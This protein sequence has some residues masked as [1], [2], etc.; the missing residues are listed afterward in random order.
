MTF[1]QQLR[2]AIH[3]NPE[4]D[5]MD[6]K[7]RF[8][9]GGEIAGYAD[10][11]LALLAAAGIPERAAVGV[12][13]R[14]KPLQ[15]AAMLG[16][17][18]GDRWLTTVYAMQT[19]GSIAQELRDTRFAAVIADRID[20]T[21]EVVA[22]AR[23]CG[24]VGLV[25]DLDAAAPIAV[26]PE[27]ATGGPGPFRIMDG[28]PGLEILSSGTTGKPK[29]IVFPTRI[30][31]RMVDS[32]KV[33]N[34]GKA[35]PSI[36]AWP[37]SGIGGMCDLVASPLMGRHVALLERFNVG[38][39]VDAVERL[40]PETV[41]G[42]PTIARMVLD[43][44]VPRERLA[45]VKYFVGGSAPM[46]PELQDEF[47]E[48][49]GIKVIW[50]YGATEFCGTII[51]WTPD[52]HAQFRKAKAGSMG[53][54]LPGITLRVLDVDSGEILPAGQQGFLSALVPQVKDEWIDTTDLVVIDDDG[55]VFH[56]GRGDGAILRG[57]HKVIP[58]KVINC[59]RDHPSVLDA[60]VVGLPD[61]RLGGVPAAVVE[62]KADMPQVDEAEL[63]EHVR[64]A[65]TAPQVPVAIRIVD[66]IPRTTSLK[67]DLG[68]VRR[69]LEAQPAE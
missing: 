8:F 66:A 62:L 42:V 41:V 2:E 65:L 11:T 59:L 1:S 45:G 48:T 10:H 30:M 15:A 49:Y 54:V 5:V 39:W 55:F 69:L 31:V 14:N 7:G 13:V 25:L 35:P 37:Y 44:K 64:A 20:W 67:A 26:H 56:H 17:L 22:A 33:S 43:A 47:E 23:E 16:L 27:L 24:T 28:E 19:P 53:K 61:R 21:P 6:F 32:V 60:A 18:T 9:T 57:G 52:L 36:L 34:M 29:R 68:A 63:K 12:I 51:S 3:A 38:D 58:E 40:K 50:A 4:K 46:P